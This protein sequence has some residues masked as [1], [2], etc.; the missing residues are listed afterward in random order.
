ME[1]SSSPLKGA[2]AMALSAT[3]AVTGAQAVEI[4]RQHAVVG[5]E[6]IRR[7]Q[8][9]EAMARFIQCIALRPDEAEYHYKFACAA[10]RAD[11]L[12]VVEEHLF[13]TVFLDPQ[14]PAAHEALALWFV[15]HGQ[16]DGA[17]EHSA[18]AVAL[19]PTRVEYVITR[20]NVLSS[21]GR[22]ADAWTIIEP[23]LAK[24]TSNVWLA[25]CYAKLAP[26]IGHE[27]KAAFYLERTLQQPNLSSADRCRLH[28]AAADLL[29]RLGHYDSAFKQA[30]IA[31][32]IGRRPF[33]P[34]AHTS[35]IYARIGYYSRRRVRSL[36]RATHGNQRPVFILGMPRSGTSLV[37]QILACHPQVYGAGELSK[38]SE[39]VCASSGAAW[40]QGTMFPDCYD[41]LSMI[42]ADELAKTYL[43]K[44]ESLNS[45]ATYVTDKMP[46]NYLYLGTVQMLLPESKVIHCI[47]DPRDTCLSCYMTDFGSQNAFSF[48][49]NH[50]ASYYRDYQRLMEHWKL[51]LDLRILEVRYEDVIADQAGQTRRMLEFLELPWDDRC[52]KF[53]ESKRMVATSSR[54]Q[55]RRPIYSSSVGRWKHYEKH[56]GPLLP[57]A[58]DS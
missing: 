7:S 6:F 13:Q 47:R 50:L 31:N 36:P 56:L 10:W 19:G 30:R 27:L 12:S 51:V 9:R 57:L 43:D 54:D 3:Q 11:E 23:M 2:S 5:D 29:D 1:Q 4:A 18:A 38:F 55:V 33:N 21:V 44:I 8:F 25:W 15:Q 37:E 26:K 17:L 35:D 16:M 45:T 46:D 34:A 20:A 22:E 42:R 58:A 28:Y 52:M 14:H 40:S 48:D 32:E 24:L 53:H 49:L 39:V 41:F